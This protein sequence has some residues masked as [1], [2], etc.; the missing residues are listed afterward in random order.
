MTRHDLISVGFKQF[1]TRMFKAGSDVFFQRRISDEFGIRYF[2]EVFHF[3]EIREG[4]Q[5]SSAS[6]EEW[7][8]EIN[9][10]DGAACNPGRAALRVM[11]YGGVKD[12]SAT[13]VLRWGNELWTRLAPNYYERND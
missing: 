3:P 10:N 2:V 11:A 4:R 8:A 12:W 9:Y 5:V 1:E 13:D 6:E 7:E